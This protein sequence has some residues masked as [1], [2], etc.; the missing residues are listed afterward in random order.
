MGVPDPRFRFQVEAAGPQTPALC[1]RARSSLLCIAC[2]QLE[3][4]RSKNAIQHCRRRRR[5]RRHRVHTDSV[6][7]DSC[8]LLCINCSYTDSYASAHKPLMACTQIHVFLAPRS[9]G[10]DSGQAGG[11]AGGRTDG[12]AGGRAGGRLTAGRW[13]T[14]GWQVGDP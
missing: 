8:V 3:R 6:H 5:R 11:Q 13:R 2:G 14:S 12:Q 10:P 1:P 4:V 9:G 7:T